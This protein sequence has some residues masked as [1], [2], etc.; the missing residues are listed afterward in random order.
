M[1][2]YRIVFRRD[3]MDHVHPHTGQRSRPVAGSAVGRGNGRPTRLAIEAEKRFW[4][5]CCKWVSERN[6]RPLIIYTLFWA[7]FV[8]LAAVIGGVR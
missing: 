2:T 8:F 7:S 3:R 1:A 6:W 4:K 5:W